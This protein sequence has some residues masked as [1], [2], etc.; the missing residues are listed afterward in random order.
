MTPTFMGSEPVLARFGKYKG[1][2]VFA[3]E[4][5]AGYAL[6]DALSN[7]ERQQATIG[8]DLPGE[9]LTAAFRDNRR[10]E[11]AGIRY[12]DL[13]REGRE[14]LEALLGVYTGRIRPGHAEVR[15]AEV[16]RHCRRPRSC[17]SSRWRKRHTSRLVRH[18][19]AAEVDPDKTAHRHRLIQ[20]LFYRWVRQVEPVLQ[21]IDT[22]NPFDPNR[23]T[24]IA[25]LGIERLDQ[26]VQRRHGTT[27]AISDRNTAHRVVLA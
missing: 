1:T 25:G 23:R 6:M 18:Q 21:K 24:A 8:H 13:P 17:A 3:A 14:R 15:W 2:R 27:R 9:L 16:K 4:E 19:L 22:Q 26:P 12:A 11:P 5:E 20:R 10:I 7:G